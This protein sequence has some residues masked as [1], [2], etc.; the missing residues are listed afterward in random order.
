MENS[1]YTEKKFLVHL[2]EEEFKE[3][4][5]KQITPLMEIFIEKENSTMKLYSRQE[6]S[7]FFKIDAQTV[8]E[9]VKFGVLPEPIK[10]GKR[11]YFTQEQIESEINKRLNK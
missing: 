6:I 1:S 8:S 4:I 11:K 3:L 5:K 7:D 2:T 10:F 9:W